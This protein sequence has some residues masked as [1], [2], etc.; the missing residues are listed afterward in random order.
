MRSEA[1]MLALLLAFVGGC[2]G[3]VDRG[4]GGESSAQEGPPTVAEVVCEHSGTRVLTPT[5]QPQQSGVH[6]HVSNETDAPAYVVGIHGLPDTVVDPG[7]DLIVAPMPP[8]RAE[9]ACYAPLNSP[10]PDEDEWQHLKVEDP[11]ELWVSPDVD[12]AGAPLGSTII[13]GFGEGGPTGEPAD[14]VREHLVGGIRASDVVEEA[15]YPGSSSITE[16][17]RAYRQATV[18]IVR[19]GRVIATAQIVAGDGEHWHLGS[20]DA[21]D[22][23]GIRP[24]FG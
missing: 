19:A 1:T 18:R 11:D 10:G 20:L 5:V 16:P 8:G 15:L 17:P 14:V 4:S 21:C 3:V 23:S 13:D 9:V 7:E 22:E 12:C 6:V 2:G 24:S